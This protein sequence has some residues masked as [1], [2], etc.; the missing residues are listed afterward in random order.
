MPGRKLHRLRRSLLCKEGVARIEHD[1]DVVDSHRLD[2]EQRICDIAEKHVRPRLLELAFDS[3]LHFG[4]GSGD[5][6]HT[7]D[8]IAPES[9][10]V[11]LKGIVVAIL[12]RP[13]LDVLGA[14]LAGDGDG[15]LVEIDGLAARLRIRVSQRTLLKLAAVARWSDRM[16]AKF[17]ALESSPN[18]TDT[19]TTIKEII[20]VEGYSVADLASSIDCFQHP[21]WRAVGVRGITVN[22]LAEHPQSGS[23]N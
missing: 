22:K 12:S 18:L 19:Y 17:V 2:R 15:F 3:E 6:A 14:E 23:K 1:S 11:G 13:E 5:F 4:G 21:D 8:R 10:V 9:L 16:A 20:N 7:L